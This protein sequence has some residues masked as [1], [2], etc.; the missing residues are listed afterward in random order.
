MTYRIYCL[1]ELE[2]C[3]G[4][5]FDPATANCYFATEDDEGKERLTKAVPKSNRYIGFTRSCLENYASEV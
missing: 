5:H 2:G 3:T 1:L 4:G